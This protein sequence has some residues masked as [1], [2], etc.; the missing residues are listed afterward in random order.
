MERGRASRTGG[1]RLT[2]RGF[3]LVEMLIVIVVLGVLAVI[4]VRGIT[5]RG[6]ENSEAG[7]LR[8]LETGIEAYWVEHDANPSEA[9]L[10]SAGL[11]RDESEMH[12]IVLGSDGSYEIVNVRTGIRVAGGIT[13]TPDE[14]TPPGD[15]EDGEPVSP[16]PPEEN[17]NGWLGT[18]TTIAGLHAVTYGSGSNTELQIGGATMRSAW[19]AM[20]TSGQSTPGGRTY[21][22]IDVS[23]IT[24]PEIARAVAAAAASYWDF[25]VYTA[26]DPD[27]PLVDGTTSYPCVYDFWRYAPDIARRPDQIGGSTIR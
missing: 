5:D 27:I 14:E 24:T 13:E 23:Q 12:D 11:L 22:L 3:T 21:I 17:Y 4:T 19:N 10:V 16:T 9:Q 8:T 15:E 18:P 20:V 1:L 2:D 7:D 6:Q 25:D 26:D